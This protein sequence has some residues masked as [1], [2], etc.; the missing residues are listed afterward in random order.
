VG[1][2]FV[3]AKMKDGGTYLKGSETKDQNRFPWTEASCR[4]ERTA[5]LMVGYHRAARGDSGRRFHEDWRGTGSAA[6][7]PGAILELVRLLIF[8]CW[9]VRVILLRRP[10]IVKG[11]QWTFCC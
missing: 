5:Q 3:V 10:G 7:G 4:P 6:R 9:L 8:V 2:W 1:Y 11:I